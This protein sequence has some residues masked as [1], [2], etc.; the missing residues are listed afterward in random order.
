MK[1]A[2]W[3]LATLLLCPTTALSI[4]TSL[5]MSA[6]LSS[7][8]MGIKGH[9]IYCTAR[10]GAFADPEAC[11]NAWAKIDRTEGTELFSPRSESSTIPHPPWLA[12][13]LRYLSDDGTCAI[14]VRA[15]RAKEGDISS[16]R[17][18]SDTAF[19]VLDKCVGSFRGGSYTAFS[20]Y[21]ALSYCCSVPRPLLPSSPSARTSGSLQPHGFAVRVLKSSGNGTR[22]CKVAIWSA[23]GPRPKIVRLCIEQS[24]ASK[25]DQAVVGQILAIGYDTKDFALHTQGVSKVMATLSL[26]VSGFSHIHALTL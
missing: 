8:P 19:Q 10:L 14:D 2:I 7:F 13:P 23:N 11:R 3:L 26:F 16:G 21:C 4:P 17:E 18:I 25:S 6:N 15:V 22:S 20:T 12:L 1:D 24:P 9:R 5:S